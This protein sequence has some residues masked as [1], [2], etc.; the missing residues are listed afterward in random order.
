LTPRELSIA[1][2]SFL[3]E[4]EDLKAKVQKLEEREVSRQIFDNQTLSSKPLET[5]KKMCP[6]CGV[7]P[8]YH[9]H[10]VKCAKNNNNKGVNGE[11]AI[12]R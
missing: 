6:H 10:V 2:K 7:Q 11:E 9:F 1:F 3:R 8:A 4:F 5:N 12:R